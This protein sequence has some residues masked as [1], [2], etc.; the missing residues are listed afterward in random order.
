M[1]AGRYTLLEQADFGFLETCVQRGHAIV[2]AGPFNSGVLAGNG[3]FN[4]GDAPADIVTRVQALAALCDEFNVPL[5]AAALQFPLAHPAIV[6]V[7]SGARSAS[8]V[9]SSVAWFNHE[10]PAAFWAALRTRHLID[11][12]APLPGKGI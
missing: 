12:A 5:Q 4:Y 3:K 1:L 6:S 7:V 2:A 8:Q 11:E 9:A 10:I